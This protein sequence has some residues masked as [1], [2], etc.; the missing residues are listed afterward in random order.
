MIFEHKKDYSLI[1]PV[2]SQP[3]PTGS[4]TVKKR[5][6]TL[7]HEHQQYHRVKAALSQN[8][9]KL[10]PTSLICNKTGQRTLHR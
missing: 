7:P 4:G 8:V 5:G 6:I 2:Y 3:E 10:M 1:N 9:I